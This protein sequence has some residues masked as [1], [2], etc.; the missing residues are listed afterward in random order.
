M[1]FIIGLGFLGDICVIV[2]QI[3][4]LWY[5]VGVNNLLRV[6]VERY[7]TVNKFLKDKF[8]ERVLK[9]SVDGGFTCPNRDGKCGYGGCIFCGDKGSGEGTKPGSVREQV[10]SHLESYR[11]ERANKFVV[12]FQNFTNTYDKVE[13][14]KAKYDECLVSDKI[15]ALAI[16]TRPD[17]IDENIAELIAS[18]KQRGLYV[19]VELGLQ[20][21]N[22]GVGKLINRG[23][24]NVDFENAVK[25]LRKYDIDVVCHV[26]VGLP[27][28]KPDDISN[29]VKFVN[30]QDIKGIKIHSTYVIEGTKL[31][32]MYKNGE[33]KE[34]DVDDYIDKVIY[35]LTHLR[36]DIVVHRITGDAPKDLLIAPS[37]NAHKKPVMNKIHK[38]MQSENLIQGMHL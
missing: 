17:C 30:R 37:W 5:N 27:E 11:A 20:T 33:Y 7:Y 36:K 25:I 21:V 13:S 8:G 10:L 12:Y 28:E 32:R 14:L 29:I 35:I 4:N 18:Y 23:Y 15:V 3:C 19:W 1:F 2:L 26:M 31:A 22:E 24:S 6:F 38:I 16:A 9:I 34:L